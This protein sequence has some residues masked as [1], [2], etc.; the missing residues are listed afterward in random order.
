MKYILAITVFSAVAKADLCESNY[1]GVPGDLKFSNLSEINETDYPKYSVYQM[2]HC[3][4]PLGNLTGAKYSLQDENEKVLYLEP[5][6]QMTGDCQT[7][8]L[9]SPLDSVRASYSSGDFAVTSVR[10]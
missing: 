8:K 7:L 10:F 6:G 4:D 5:I 1:V 3:V 2:T 9:D